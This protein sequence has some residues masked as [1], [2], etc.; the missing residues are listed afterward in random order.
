MRAALCYAN[1]ANFAASSVCGWGGAPGQRGTLRHV[2]SIERGAL[3]QPEWLHTDAG[4]FTLIYTRVLFFY[5]FIRF[6]IMMFYL[7][8]VRQWF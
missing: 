5:V 6:W 8:V 4:T 3:P 7:S 2:F 1:E